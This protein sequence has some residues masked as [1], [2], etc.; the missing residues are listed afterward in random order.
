MMLVFVDQF[1]AQRFTN[2]LRMGSSFLVAGDKYNCAHE[3][4]NDGQFV[5]RRVLRYS[6]E[7][8]YVELYTAPARYDDIIESGVITVEPTSEVNAC[9]TQVNQTNAAKQICIGVNT[10]RTCSQ[11]RG[12]IPI[13]Q[14]RVV[15]LT[16]S[17]CFIGFK[18]TI[19]ANIK[20]AKWRLFEIAAGFKNIHVVGALVFN[21]HAQYRC[22]SIFF[23]GLVLGGF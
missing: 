23:G 8:I 3:S 6:R 10:D 15:T 21:M 2:S 19:F 17:N 16:C 13:Y 14:G 22:G 1:S 11:A 7:F 4:I 9:V 5:L 12:P 20:I 18:A